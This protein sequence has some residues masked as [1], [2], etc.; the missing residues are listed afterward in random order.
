MVKIEKLTKN[1]IFYLALKKC[2]VC[3]ETELFTGKYSGMYFVQFNMLLTLSL[4]GKTLACINNPVL[5]DTIL[6]QVCRIFF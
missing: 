6:Y 4:I 3:Y 5:T 2:L 1:D